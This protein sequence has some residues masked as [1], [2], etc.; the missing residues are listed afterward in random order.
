MKK[1]SFL[2]MLL[3]LVILNCTMASASPI[4]FVNCNDGINGITGGAAG[5]VVRV[6]NRQDLAKYAKASEPY[7]IIVEG[8]YEGNGLNRQKDVI[9]VNS[10]KT[11]VGVKGAELAGIGLNINGKQN[12][13]IR[14]LIIHHAD[15][16]GIAA[17][18]SHHIWIDHC[19]V[20]SQ[21][22]E[23]EDWDGLIDLTVGSSYLT[24]SYCYLHDHHKA[25]LLNSGTMHFEDNGK[26]RTTYH[27]NAFLRIDQ[28]CPRIGYGLGHVFNN[29]Y[30]DIGW[31]AIGVH[32]QA[33]VV[34]E[35]NWFGSN[36]KHP[37]EQMY[38]NSL[39]DASCAFFTERGSHF[40]AT[41]PTGFNYE[42]TGTDFDPAMWY[43]SA[44][45]VDDADVAGSIY[46]TQTGPIEGLEHEPI[47]WPGNGA[48]DLPLDTKLSYSKIEGMTGAEVY[49]GTSPDNLQILPSATES[50]Q[51]SS[52]VAGD[53]QSPSPTSNL[54]P[55]SPS[56]TR[57]GQGALTSNLSPLTCYYWRVKALTA[58]GSY[59]SPLYRFTTAGEKATKPQPVNGEKNAQLR[60][61]T[62][63]EAKTG[64]MALAWRP[65]FNAKD[66]KVYL[67]TTEDDL[68]NNLIKT[69][70]ATTCNPGSLLYGPTYY[71]RVDVEQKDGT[72]V[73][74]DVWTF[75]APAK[76]INVGRTEME[77]LARSAYAYL[78]REDGAWFKASNDSV[79]VGEAGPG[80]ITGVWAG[81]S[82]S[83]QVS[84]DFY[85]EKAGQAWMGL[86]VNDVLVDSWKGVKQYA[87]TTHQIKKEVVLNPGDQ[88][89]IDF[90]TQS[91]MRCRIDCIDIKT[92]TTGI[93]EIIQPDALDQDAS[94]YNLSGQKV[95]KDY[96]GIVIFNGKKM[97]LK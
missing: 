76:P 35:N 62:S 22:E 71:W 75:S 3:G 64:A 89:R 79:T 1:K 72:I 10:N 19:E 57:G 55:N 82:G 68:D 87:M 51:P 95:G 77:H 53:L 91:K 45:A 24:V 88:I 78:E 94:I 66:Y 97:I 39:D 54:S 31:Y 5:E 50:G 49:F 46:P 34:S 7:T 37:F 47:L 81:E 17:R 56:K 28:R 58:N 52:S 84:I 41:P 15:P 32:T 29:Y 36:V 44:F 14:N 48:I 6:N 26:N 40:T 21:D 65:A 42:P 23:K 86:S 63:A 27:H 25:C 9:E 93:G 85:D 18:N 90:Y 60:A 96:K 92:G 80:A 73:K 33:K 70:T 61:A 74:G 43:E 38:A 2:M 20:Y 30:Q 11:I 13:I 69:T 67:S 12:I 4:G 16:D 83:Y 8:K 59:D